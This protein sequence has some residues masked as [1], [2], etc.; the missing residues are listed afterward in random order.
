MLFEKKPDNQNFKAL[1]EEV[2]STVKPLVE[3][4]TRAKSNKK[5]NPYQTLM[6]KN[7]GLVFKATADKV[8]TLAQSHEREAKLSKNKDGSNS[9]AALAEGV[10]AGKP[11][12]TVGKT[13]LEQKDNLLAN[14][15]ESVTQV[16]KETGI[17]KK[18]ADLGESASQIVKEIELDKKFANLAENAGVALTTASNATA[19]AFKDARLDEKLSEATSKVSKTLEQAQLPEKVLE[20]ANV[21]PGVNIKNPKKTAKALRRSRRQAL[22]KANEYQHQLSKKLPFVEQ[23]K[24]DFS[25]ARTGLLVLGGGGL[26]YGG[27]TANNARIWSAVKPLISQLPGVSEEYSSNTSKTFYKVAG[28][29]QDSTPIVFVH[30]IGAG[31]SSYEWLQ[32][33]G[34]FAQQ[35][36][37]YA[38]DLLGFGNSDRPRERYTSEVYI[39]QLTDFLEK[40]VK[41]PSYVVASS[42]SASYAVQVAY[43]HP[44][45]IK[46]LVLTEP[47]G[48]NSKAPGDKVQITPRFTYTLLNLPVIGKSIYSLVASRTSI[49]TFL[50]NQ[51]FYNK[52]LITDA[53]VEQYYT[54]GH[55]PGAEFAPPSFFTGLLNAEIGQTIGKIE[56][57]ILVVIGQQSQITTVDEAKA[58]ASRNKHIR[59]EV[60]NQARMMVQWEKAEEF[61][62]KVGEFLK[63]NEAASRLA[64]TEDRSGR[65]SQN[66]PEQ[67]TVLSTAEAS[68]PI[69]TPIEQNN[70]DAEEE[71]RKHREVFIG[72]TQASGTLIDLIDQE[73]I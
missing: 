7:S 71:I 64:S 15:S 18:L 46:K 69:A 73:S 24:K 38:F 21:L 50:E 8:D 63:D 62:Q 39:R 25:W 9:L 30:G 35:H 66:Q 49:R 14:L 36:P 20:A 33:F 13:V 52:N 10:V 58:L 34:Y 40:M 59:L 56:Q 23:K 3:T 45:L 5:N 67:A 60:I 32:N 22:K 68:T 55:Q 19:K 16:V 26:V 42:L 47:T 61:N 12:Q 2:I 6:T 1:K 4:I 65:A 17:D 54:A 70:R 51:L 37:V 29:E 41:Q 44:D 11:T 53:M 43:R 72:D 27:L 48:L 28:R 57:P 31:N